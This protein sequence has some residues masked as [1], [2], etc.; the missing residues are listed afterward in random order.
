[1]I[2]GVRGISFLGDIAIDDLYF[3]RQCRIPRFNSDSI[4][5]VNTN[6]QI[7]ASQGRVEIL[8]EG[9][10][11]TICDDGWDMM[12]AN[13]VCRQLGKDFV[14]YFIWQPCVNDIYFILTGYPK[15]LSF[16]GNG[17]LGMGNGTIWYV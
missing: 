8:H 7:I 15:A 10:W 9:V 12:D 13:V 11:G 14:I 1:M 2:V 3:S 4:R 6:G 17:E 16:R 5:L